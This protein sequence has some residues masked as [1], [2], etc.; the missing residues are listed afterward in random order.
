MSSRRAT[1]KSSEFQRNRKIESL[2][3]TYWYQTTSISGL[4]NY[5][6]QR[7][8][9]YSDQNICTPRRTHKLNIYTPKEGMAKYVKQLLIDLKEDINQ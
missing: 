8:S 7:V 9:F 4:K 1:L 6:R 3:W 5:K 2:V